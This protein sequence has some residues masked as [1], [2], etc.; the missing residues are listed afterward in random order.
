MVELEFCDQLFEA[1]LN[2]S[3]PCSAI[4]VVAGLLADS[5]NGKIRF[6]VAKILRNLS[7]FDQL[8]EQMVDERVSSTL[9]SLLK[10]RKPSKMQ[11]TIIE[12]MER[13]STIQVLCLTT[14]GKDNS[15]AFIGG[16]ADGS[17][18]GRKI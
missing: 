7:K 6:N 17:A 2:A 12:A 18:A 14:A 3:F 15:D 13:I 9:V 4:A 8:L 5:K 16:W 10:F 11:D 1:I